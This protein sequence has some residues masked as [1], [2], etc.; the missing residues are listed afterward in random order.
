MFDYYLFH[1]LEL[2]YIEH[3]IQEKES[4]RRNYIPF[5]FQFIVILNSNSSKF[6]M[7]WRK[8]IIL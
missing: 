3:E 2:H 8:Q 4:L 7:K 6:N 5:Y 1:V